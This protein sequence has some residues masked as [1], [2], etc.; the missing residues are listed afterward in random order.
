L[1]VPVVWCLGATADFV[2]GK[3]DRGPAWLHQNQEWLARLITEPGRLWRRYLIG[4]PRFLGRM[5]VER[6]RSPS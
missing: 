4:N 6:F 5:L 2:S 3:V 1:E